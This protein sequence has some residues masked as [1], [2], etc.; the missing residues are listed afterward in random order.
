MLPELEKIKTRREA[1]QITQKKFAK[2]CGIKP[3]ML[4][5]V[6]KR[7]ANPSYDLW[8]KIESCLD[9]E[10][11]KELSNV[12]TAGQVCI[13]SVKTVKAT[14]SI[15]DAIDKMKR[16]DFS[17]LPVFSYSNCVGLITESSILKYELAGGSIVHGKIKDS[18]EFPPPIINER[19]PITPQII[20]LLSNSNCILV[21][22]K[23]G[24]IVGIITKIDAIRKV[25]SK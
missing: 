1:L 7:N 8:V 24:E 10:E 2:M 19:A 6:E 9:I 14:D 11:A 3:S 17:Q 21:S 22:N 12:K 25:K 5:M 4:N 18:M 15:S 16:F 13:T 23:I 20:E